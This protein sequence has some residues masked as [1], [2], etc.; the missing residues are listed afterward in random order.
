MKTMVTIILGAYRHLFNAMRLE[1][2]EEWCNKTIR[3]FL[4]YILDNKFKKTGVIEHV[5]ESIRKTEE[6]HGLCGYHLILIANKNKLVLPTDI[7][8]NNLKN[9]SLKLEVSYDYN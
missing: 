5:K 9:G 2:P 8:S 6:R 3:D 7:I 1:L 4:F